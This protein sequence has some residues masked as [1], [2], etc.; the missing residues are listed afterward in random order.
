MKMDKEP[1]KKF[2]GIL[3][4]M[5]SNMRASQD[6]SQRKK[7]KELLKDTNHSIKEEITSMDDVEKFIS[8]VVNEIGEQYPLSPNEALDIPPEQLDGLY[9]LAHSLYS[10]GKYDES[11][12]LFRLLVMIEPFEYKYTFAL[13][14]CLQMETKYLDSAT[15]YLMAASIDTSTPMPHYHAA[16]CYLKL[17]D[18]GSACISLGL[19]IDAAGSQEQYVILKERCQLTRDRL[20]KLIKKKI[21]EKKMKRVKK[22]SE[23]AKKKTFREES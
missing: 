15:T 21:K 1:E 14:A 9:A 7:M 16:E 6:K 5:P 12:N 19:A 18:P 23:K 2:D 8:Q 4:G 22:T 13:A 17:H 10:H 3:P 11:G 20:T